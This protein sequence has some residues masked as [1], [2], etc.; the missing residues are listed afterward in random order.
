[1]YKG[2][3]VIKQRN[4]TKISLFHIL[5]LIIKKNAVWWFEYI[6]TDFDMQVDARYKV[7]NYGHDAHNI[8]YIIFY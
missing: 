4:Q 2:W 7:W 6:K 5:F 8:F 3:Y 1:M